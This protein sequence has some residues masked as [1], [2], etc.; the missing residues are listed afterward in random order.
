MKRKLNE[1][2][3]WKIEQR[4]NASGGKYL[5][6]AIDQS[7]S[8]DDTYAVRN[9]LKEFGAKWDGVGKQ[10]YFAL[11]SDPE[12]RSIQIEKFVK[13]CVEY[14][15]SVETVPSE[16]TSD[17]A[18]QKIISQI[19]SVLNSDTPAGS[20]EE[21]EDTK[22]IKKRLEEFKQELIASFKNNTFREKMG[23]IIKFRQAQGAGYS[24]L[25]SILIM[26]QRPDAKMVKSVTKWAQ[27]NKMIKK[28]AKP[29]YLWVPVGK[30]AHTE[31]ERLKIEVDFYKKLQKL[32][33]T[34][35]ISKKQLRV[36]DKEKLEKK[37]NEVVPTSFK[38]M[39]R[40]YDY[41]DVEQ[42]PGKED[43][44]GNMNDFDTVEWF[45]G[46]TAADE[47]SEKLFDAV[48][49]TIKD[50]GVSVSFADDLGGARG[51]SKGGNIEVLQDAPKNIGSVSTLVHELS[52]ELLHQTYLKTKGGD[53]EDFAKYFVGREFG[54][55]IVEQQAEISAWIVMRNFGYDMQTAKNYVACWGGDEKTAAYAFDT[56]A[57][58]STRIIKGINENL[59]AINEGFA[60]NTV[61]TGLDI[62]ELVGLGDVY[63][64]GKEEI[65]QEE[66]N[67][68][69]KTL[70]ESF[71]RMMTRL[72]NVRFL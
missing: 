35:I 68:K 39:P 29:I 6:A 16:G 28:G 14:L 66:S 25:N 49:Q 12:K 63:R 46:K 72:N 17:D 48:I 13:P 65:G 69:P 22:S 41:A 42:V 47:K 53:K 64:R 20:P 11:S 23:P 50:L 1:A 26:V 24:I 54:K 44:I 30:R 10:W 31:D 51:V 37:L 36:G 34:E 27:A 40:F 71:S 32:Y 70:A 19:D 55:G 58:V 56:V 45:D 8:T 7:L 43:V 33:G 3:E 5:I 21:D 4:T 60:G 52:H 59:G 62:A 9:K 61:I 2:Y 38:L 18:L 57:N 67:V 15:K